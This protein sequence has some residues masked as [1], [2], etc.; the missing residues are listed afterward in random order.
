MLNEE[1]RVTNKKRKTRITL[2]SKGAYNGK[3]ALV[4]ENFH[5]KV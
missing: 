3:P 5:T 4:V 1:T 2:I